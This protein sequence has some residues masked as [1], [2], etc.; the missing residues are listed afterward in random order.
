MPMKVSTVGKMRLDVRRGV[1]IGEFVVAGLEGL[2][3]AS[4]V[5]CAALISASPANADDARQRAERANATKIRRMS[6]SCIETRI[7][8]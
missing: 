7:I 6:V 2:Q 1:G 5:P 8:A 3:L 4:I